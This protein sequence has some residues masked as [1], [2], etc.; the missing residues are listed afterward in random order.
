M[1]YRRVT[2][3]T[4]RQG[5]NSALFIDGKFEGTWLSEKPKISDLEMLISPSQLMALNIFRL[6]E[7]DDEEIYFYDD[8]CDD[9]EVFKEWME[10]H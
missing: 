3:Y 10:T 2:L 9:E 8:Y 4:W 5:E 6:R 7:N 1:D